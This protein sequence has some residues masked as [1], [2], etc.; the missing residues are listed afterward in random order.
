MAGFL[1]DGERFVTIEHGVSI[2]SFATG[3]E[4]ASARYPSNYAFHPE[5]SPDGRHLGV[6]GYGSMYIYDTSALGKPQKLSSGRSYGGFV[7]LAFHPGGRAMAVIHGGPTLVKVYDPGTLRPTR[8][9]KW[10]L[11][12]LGC[13][14][15]SPDGSLGAAGSRDG[16]IVVWDVDEE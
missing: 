11:G 8:T 13:L 7:G 10:R 12:P 2:R 4:L 15:Y 6:I 5:V 1:P 9:Y 16:R 14:A 3:A